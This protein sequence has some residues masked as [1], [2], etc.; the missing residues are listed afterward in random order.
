MF[1]REFLNHGE[2]VDLV[3]ALY[4]GD[5]LEPDLA[6]APALKWAKLELHKY[7]TRI[8]AAESPST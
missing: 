6:D 3:L 4:H 1:A 5:A 2:L 8:V 7:A